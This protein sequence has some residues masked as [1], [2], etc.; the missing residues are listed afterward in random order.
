MNGMCPICEEYDD[1]IFYRKVNGYHSN[2]CNKCGHIYVNH[3]NDINQNEINDYYSIDFYDNYMDDGYENAYQKYLKQDFV[4]KIF[5]LDK[6]L[7][8][9]SSI[10]EVGSGP[11]YFASLLANKGYKVTPIELTSGA[12]EYAKKYKKYDKIFHYDLENKNNPIYGKQFDCVI[13]WA[14]IEHVKHPLKF[15]NL[16]KSY[17]KKNGLIFID[18]GVTNSFTR[19]IDSGYSKWL[20]PP[21]HLH[22]FSCNS[23]INV[24]KKN[25][26]K[27]EFFDNKWNVKGLSYF[28]RFLRIIKLILNFLNKVFKKNKPGI[29]GIIGLVVA[30]K[31]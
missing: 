4:R 31:K 25:D 18:T 17:S 11:G 7:S 19:N 22:V 15:I 8:V 14:T 30:K 6:F 2:I 24:F 5:L 26:L 1:Q 16:L 27:I 9:G 23:I 29:F 20:Q 21:W 28:K 12:R 13:S 3:L 10:L